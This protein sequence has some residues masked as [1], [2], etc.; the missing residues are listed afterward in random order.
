[1]MALTVVDILARR[2]CFERIV[3]FD[4]SNNPLEGVRGVARNAIR[5]AKRRVS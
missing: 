2:H 3:R 4:M 5:R 1:M